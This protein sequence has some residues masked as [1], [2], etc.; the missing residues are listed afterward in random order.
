MTVTLPSDLH[1]DLDRAGYFPQAAIAVLERAIAGAEVSAYLVRPETAFDGPEVR[2]HLTVLALTPRHL[3]VVHV[4]DD[5]ADDLN[6]MQVIASTE[7]VRLS[8]IVAVGLSQV[9]PTDGSRVQDQESE[10]T[11]GIT[12][13]NTRRLDLERAWCDDPHC[14]ADHGYSGTASPSDIAL[15][16]SAIADGAQAVADALA[17]HAALTEA[18]DL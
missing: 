10:V 14:Q 6:P 7:K 18:V 17:F 11:L 13:G 8:R 2:R 1:G 9:F 16:V 15:R 4:D 3:V 5:P 12:W